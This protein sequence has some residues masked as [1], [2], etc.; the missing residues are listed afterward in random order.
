MSWIDAHSWNTEGKVDQMS[1]RFNRLV[2]PDGTHTTYRPIANRELLSKKISDKMIFMSHKTGDEQ[3]AGVAYYISKKHGIHVYMAEWDDNVEDDSSELPDYIMD[4][5]RRSD[6]LLVHVIAAIALSMWIGYEI[7]GAHALEKK[8][9]K[10]MYRE[11]HGLP[12]VVGALERLGN[13]DELDR[14]II[15]NVL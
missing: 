14:W 2:R 3:A 9:A 7:G 5:I 15:R 6:G 8:R 1:V 12:S 10:V 13:R 11:I 4:E